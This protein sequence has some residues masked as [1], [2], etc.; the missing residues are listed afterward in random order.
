VLGLP[1]VSTLADL[2]LKKGDRLVHVRDGDIPG[3]A[4]DQACIRGIDAQLLAG[5]KVKVTPT[6][7]GEDAN[8]VLLH[9][10]P[11]ILN[12]LISQAREAS[13]SFDG[14]IIRLCQ[15]EGRAF[16]QERDT[17]RKIFK[18]RAG[19]IDD[20]VKKLR[21]RPAAAKDAVDDGSAA[22]LS[23]PEDPL[24]T[25]PV[26]PL[27]ALLDRIKTIILHF[28]VITEAQAVAVT[29]WVA[30]G[31]LLQSLK[32]NLEIFPKLAVQSKDPASGKTTLLKL[33]W[34]LLPRAKLWTYPSGAFLVR[35]I[36]QGSPSLCLDEP[37]YAEDRNLLRVINAAHERALA[38]V[39][40]LVPDPN[41]GWVPRE[42]PV[43]VP[44]ALARLG[45]FSGAQQSRSIVIWMLPKLRGEIR[46][47]LRR[48]VVPELVDVRRQLAAWA[49]AVPAWHAPAIPDVLLN[50]DFNNWEPLL[51]VAE[52]AGEEWRS[53]AHQAVGELVKLERAPSITERILTSIW[54][55][56]QPD[57]D[58]APTR[59]FLP[60]TELLDALIADTEEDWATANGGKP[61]NFE[62]LGGRLRH[63]LDPPGPQQE[64]Y[65]DPGTGKRR[66][67]KGYSFVQFQNAFARYV[68][69]HPLSLTEAEKPASPAS[70]GSHVKNPSKTVASAEAGPEA[71]PTPEAGP[72][73]GPTPE[74]GNPASGNPEKFNGLGPTEAG[75]AGEA[76]FPGDIRDREG[77]G[78]A[79]AST[80]ANGEDPD[81]IAPG[82][83]RRIGKIESIVR[84]TRDENPDW[85]IAQ[86]AKR[87]G[88]APSVVRRILGE[89]TPS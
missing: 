36:E 77:I 75:E 29:L 11:D 62:W 87:V 46:E 71:G 37:Q 60:S 73:A 70:P 8:Q 16:D 6:A 41:G 22:V 3:S 7:T 84:A 89:D 49:D 68:G 32:V 23:V 72:E 9:W 66:N 76:G 43:W 47:P 14:R 81:G 74:A 1:G 61:I 18:V 12:L 21:P 79:A 63:L 33:I 56:Y 30:A 38:Y 24:W 44:M 58:E 55:I 80:A 4:A 69:E 51:F 27:A 57:P 19:T 20:E 50:R 25:D 82:P 54:K 10:G 86:I 65:Y 2:E 34:N 64:N 39:P 40:L 15:L 35:A 17:I 83:K 26:P 53:A 45:E 59:T 85:S 78:S 48:P 42:F 31:H 5:V 88:R 28:V 52:L 13:L 67:R